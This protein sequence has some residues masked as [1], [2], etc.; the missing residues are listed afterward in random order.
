[1]AEC[2]L[3]QDAECDEITNMTLFQKTILIKQ[4]RADDLIVSLY[5]FSPQLTDPKRSFHNISVCSDPQAKL[6]TKKNSVE[7]PVIKR[8]RSFFQ[9]KLYL[10]DFSSYV[11]SD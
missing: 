9:I 2:K 4:S 8:L 1:M 3:E 5:L 10:S 11:F 7:L 6:R